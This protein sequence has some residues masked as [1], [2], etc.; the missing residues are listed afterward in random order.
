[1]MALVLCFLYRFFAFCM[2]W[3]EIVRVPASAFLFPFTLKP[4]LYKILT[5]LNKMIHFLCTN[6]CLYLR[7]HLLF[8]V[9]QVSLH[10]IAASLGYVVRA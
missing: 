7:M 4:V 3:P 2:Y 8:I 5:V 6:F 10:D 9:V 1:M